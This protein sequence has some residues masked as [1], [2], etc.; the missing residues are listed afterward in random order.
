V[1]PAPVAEPEPADPGIADG[2]THQLD[3]RYIDLERQ[4]GWIASAITTAIGLAGTSGFLLASRAGPWVV[5]PVIAGVA[6]LIV[7]LTWW[8]QRWP[9]IEYRHASYRVDADGLEI[10]RGV[11]FRAVTTVPRSRVQHT[12][13]SQGPLQRRFGLATLIVHTAGSENA[14]VDLPGLPHEVALR[15][16]DH[17]LPRNTDNAV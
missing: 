10:R 8:W 7:L 17:L 16:R 13:V 9:A 12:D 2:L 14:E 4:T 11:Y 15:I 1:D 6:A 5:G 3:P